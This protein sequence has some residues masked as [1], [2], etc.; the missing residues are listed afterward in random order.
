MSVTNG[1]IKFI[2]IYRFLS[3]SLDKLVKTVVDIIH[4]ALKNLKHDFVDNDEILNIVFEIKTL[5]QEG[6]VGKKIIQ[7]NLK[8]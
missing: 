5:I 4:K 1:C 8:N 7:I 2:D 3:S 6:R